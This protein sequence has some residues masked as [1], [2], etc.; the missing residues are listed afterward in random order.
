MPRM[1][2]G[3]LFGFGESTVDEAIRL[4]AGSGRFETIDRT[5]DHWILGFVSVI[6]AVETGS[7]LRWRFTGQTFADWMRS[8][9]SR[10]AS[11][12]ATTLRSFLRRPDLRASLHQLAQTHRRFP[13]R[14]LRPVP[15]RIFSRLRQL[16]KASPAGKRRTGIEWLQFLRQHPEVIQDEVEAADLVDTLQRPPRR[17]RPLGLDDLITLA[18]WRRPELLL[19]EETAR[20]TGAAELSFLQDA[21]QRATRFQSGAL[22]IKSWWV[23]PTHGYRVAEQEQPTG[24]AQFLTFRADGSLVIRTHYGQKEAASP[25]AEQSAQLADQEVGY[26]EMIV[27]SPRYS[28]LRQAGGTQY[29]EWLLQLPMWPTNFRANHFELRNL[30]LHLR[31]TVR[32]T[33]SAS[34]VL[35]L[36]ELQSDWHQGGSRNGY[37]ETGFDTGPYPLAPWRETWHELGLRVLLYRAAFE[38]HSLVAWPTPRMIGRLSGW[39]WLPAMEQF[40]GVRF[41]SAFNRLEQ[42]G[43][44]QRIPIPIR[45][46]DYRHRIEQTQ[47]GFF[48]LVKDSGEITHS[49]LPTWNEA[50]TLLNRTVEEQWLELPGFRLSKR[51]MK[52]APC[53]GLP[54]FGTWRQEDL[55]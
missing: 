4:L 53:V 36:E 52:R 39:D 43:L 51:F 12:D 42:A 19:L 34:S 28:G 35:F 31:T 25:T 47:D 16:L 22:P 32:T 21:G 45:S 5:S 50:A 18:D 3:R 6:E 55:M 2:D 20:T 1:A 38:G 54:L 15:C 29:R 46:R 48:C 10:T 24:P 27:A 7:I 33:R 8:Y 41:E 11:R 37:G 17:V 30:L 44:G 23:N 26:V 40:Y 49:G 13:E 14:G 9:A